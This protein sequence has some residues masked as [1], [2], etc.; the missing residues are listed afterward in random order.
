MEPTNL[1]GRLATAGNTYRGLLDNQL[2]QKY[3]GAQIDNFNSEIAT[4]QAALAKQQQISDYLGK[5][6]SPQ[7]AQA[8]QGQLGSG[9]F[10]VLPTMPGQPDIPAQAPQ[11]GSR[12]GS[13]S[14]DQVAGLHA[15]GGPNL[16]DAY[17]FAREGIERKP[18]SFYE[19]MQGRRS[20]VGDPTKGIDFKDGRIQAMPGAETIANLAG[21]TADAQEGAKAKFDLVKVYNPATQ[22]E[23]FVSRAQV[24]NRPTQQPSQPAPAVSLPSPQAGVKGGFTGDPAAV[25]AAI[26]S[27]KDPQERANALLAFNEQANR[28]PGFAAGGNF[29][30]GPSSGEAAS[31]AAAKAT[32]EGIAKDVVEQR[33]G[34]MNAGFV[35]PSNIARYQQISK[36]LA[37][38]D[39]GALT[40]QG[41]HLAS[42]A[43]SLGIKIDKN[44]PNK[45]AASALANEAALKLRDPSGGAGMPGA[46][47]DSDR[48]FLTSMTPNMAQSAQGRQ[49]IISSYIAVQQRNQQVA[50]FARKYEQK[51]GKLDN[52]F[53]SQLQAW[54]NSNPLFKGQ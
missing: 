38:V 8:G 43:N 45:E 20:Y 46:M 34:I 31:A 24:L 23:E 35:A 40:A 42:L 22:R 32:A 19:D 16:M 21:Q 50:D 28:T 44:L 33:K 9:T 2:K 18:G 41:T 1:A 12:I 3:I 15:I 30:A 52:G 54:S 10:G 13:M 37:N 47:S 11:G 49:Q 4:R 36:L 26:N 51:Y 7:P 39:G 27:I 25:M 5:L 48:N 29:A 17:K 6:L 14:I 53:F